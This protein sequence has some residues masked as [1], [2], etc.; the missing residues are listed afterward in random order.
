M[1]R[2]LRA[3]TIVAGSMLT[4]APAAASAAE[5]AGTAEAV[6]RAK[7]SG[8]HEGTSE[9]GMLRIG[10]QRKSPEGWLMTIRRMSQWHGVALSGDEERILVKH[11][12]DTQ[13]L[14]PG[15]AAPFR[16][17]LEHRPG[18]VESPD[19]ADLATFCARC[20]S[21]ARAGLQRRSEE[22]WT[23]LVHMHL[24]Q[25][26]TTE[27]HAMAR[28]RRWWEIASTE[29]PRKLAEKWPLAS[30][31]W[32]SWRQRRPADPAGR[33]RV[34]GHRPGK[35]DYSGRLVVRHAGPDRYA[36]SYRLAYAD[37]STVSG[38]GSALI[39]TGHE[40]RGSVTL[41]GE[42]ISEVFTISPD[43]ATIA[44]RWFRDAEPAIGGEMRAVRDVR[45][46]VLAVHPAHAKVGE[47]TRITIIG[48]HLKGR[49]DLGP[50]VAIEALLST[51]VDAVT[52]AVRASPEAVGRHDVAVG[53]AAAAGAFFVYDKIDA[54][55]VEPPYT[56]ARI[57]GNGGPVPP[58]PAQFEAVGYM[59]GADGEPG[60]EDDVRIGIMP[61]AWSVEN[62]DD[63][64][65]QL[66][67]A[68]FGGV[69]DQAGLFSPGPAGMN[70]ERGGANNIANLFVRA[71]VRDGGA[72]VEGRGRLIV[73]PQRWVNPP[74]D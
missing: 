51:G 74:L 35:G 15:E 37:G 17:L 25:W 16:Y 24:G 58:V 20:H 18:M 46:A 52:V 26:P 48:N 55:R 69:I 63:W 33:W 57:G 60:T 45:P 49:I 10:G 7:C 30:A 12:A 38:D 14:A 66:K 19:D 2:T 43:G 22:E 5:G 27:Y 11:L 34:A 61:A 40:W 70:P 23:K 59:R 62:F 28:D 54:V 72:E 39:Y 4:I 29:I 13:G 3:L 31:E 67:D 71:V 6:L 21:Y 36:L 53:E 44:G 42:E 50:G 41:G 65:A 56:I 73:A 8:C 9:G 64:A 32:D 68:Q 47:L 1:K